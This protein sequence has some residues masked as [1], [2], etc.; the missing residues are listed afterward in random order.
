L[1]RFISLRS[2]NKNLYNFYK[3]ACRQ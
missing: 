3:T 1:F 2:N